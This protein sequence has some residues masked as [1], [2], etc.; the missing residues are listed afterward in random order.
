MVNISFNVNMKSYHKICI[1]RSLPFRTDFLWAK[2]MGYTGLQLDDA[3]G[4]SV[5]TSSKPVQ[6][7]T[8]LDGRVRHF[9]LIDEGHGTGPGHP[10]VQEIVRAAI[11]G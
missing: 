9:K 3:D 11:L 10:V 4:V 1:M 5:G 8:Y 2:A 7:Y 6:Q